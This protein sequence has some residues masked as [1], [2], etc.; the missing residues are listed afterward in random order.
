MKTLPRSGLL[1]GVL[2]GLACAS[3]PQ[4]SP[5]PVLSRQSA[6]TSALLIGVSAPSDNVAWL[7]G[8]GGTYLRTLDGGATWQVSQV[9][10]AD[11][12]QFRDVHAEDANRAW[13]LSIGPGSQSRIFHTNDGGQ[14]WA[15]QFVNTDTLAFYDCLDFWDAERGVVFGDEV[16]GKLQILITANGGNSWRLVDPDGLPAALEGEGGFAASGTCVIT[17]SDGRGW[18]GT[19]NGPE[20]RVLLTTD[21]GNT[22]QAVTTPIASGTGKGV[23]SVAFRDDRTGAVL[24][25][26]LGE[27]DAVTDN[28]AITRD[29]G[30][31]WK[32]AGRPTFAGAVFGAAFSPAPHS[33][34]IAVGP[35]GASASSDLGAT[36]TPVDTASYWG[37][38]FA[39]TGNGWMVGPRGRITR[40]TVGSRR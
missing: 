23:A 37:V 38:G 12:L 31:T 4:P 9:P 8:T 1:V 26:P 16:G 19:G 29:G 35:K 22:W 32:T 39:P 7:S 17:G 6:N 36:W 2:T 14:H 27:P 40:L 24:G 11:S 3:P 30:R 10:G 15:E 34:L 28:V 21:Y 13:L 25:G 33:T 18:I 20:S 5:L